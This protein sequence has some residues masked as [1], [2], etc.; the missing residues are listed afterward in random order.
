MAGSAARAVLLDGDLLLSVAG[1][2]VSHFRAVEAAVAASFPAAQASVKISPSPAKSVAAGGA[3]RQDSTELASEGTVFQIGAPKGGK[4]GAASSSAAGPAK[5]QRVVSG[6]RLDLNC[7]ASD[8]N[9]LD[10]HAIL[11]WGVLLG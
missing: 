8:A 7:T 4:R 10:A 5:R 3:D 11:G 6:A 2:P 1:R 9:T